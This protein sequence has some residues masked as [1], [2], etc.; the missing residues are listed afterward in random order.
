MSEQTI[1][2]AVD[3]TDAINQVKAA[4]KQAYLVERIQEWFNRAVPVPTDKNRA[5][6]LG[7]HFEEIAEMGEAL[8]DTT[9][10]H[11][12]HSTADDFKQ[13]GTIEDLYGPEHLI[14][15]VE[16]LDSLADQIV[17]A[18]GVAHMFG[19]DLASALAEVNE[20]NWSKF[21]ENGQPIFNE[22]GKIAKGPNYRKPDLTKFVG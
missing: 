14:N 2:V 21:D 11:D 20:S 6:Q 19:M 13:G 15:R 3:A 17:T 16:L 1:T 5:V 4:E 7:C 9:I 8:G 18:I 22:H 10:A 12:M